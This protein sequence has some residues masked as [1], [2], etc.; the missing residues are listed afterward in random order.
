MRIGVYVVTVIVISSCFQRLSDEVS[1]SIYDPESENF[2][3]LNPDDV[4]F[5]VLQENGGLNYFYYLNWEAIRAKKI[6]SVNAIALRYAGSIQNKVVWRQWA[7]IRL[8][9]PLPTDI[10]KGD[11]FI[12][13]GHNRDFHAFLEFYSKGK[14]KFRT[15]SQVFRF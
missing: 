8:V 14:F 7:Q 1:S 3:G 10:S 12:K 11:A 5:D 6:D 13:I 4:A 2:Q 9:Q 15:R